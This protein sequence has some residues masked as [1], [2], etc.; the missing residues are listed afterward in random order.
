MVLRKSTLSTASL[1]RGG[2]KEDVLPYL[3]VGCEGREAWGPRMRGGSQGWLDVEINGERRRRQR[4]WGA[5]RGR[6]GC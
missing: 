1:V 2:G 4:G 5:R 6:C 3:V